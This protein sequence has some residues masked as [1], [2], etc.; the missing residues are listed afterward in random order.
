MSANCLHEAMG[1]VAYY[2]LKPI[3]AC[4]TIFYYVWNAGRILRSM[5]AASTTPFNGT[6]P[7]LPPPQLYERLTSSRCSDRS[8]DIIL[9]RQLAQIEA[10]RARWSLN[11]PPSYRTYETTREL[12]PQL[13]EFEFGLPEKEAGG[14]IF[15]EKHFKIVVRPMEDDVRPKP[16]FSQPH[17]DEKMIYLPGSYGSHFGMAVHSTSAGIGVY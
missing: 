8:T 4:H 1:C 12:P 9:Q 11:R 10:E 7:S 3:V 2:T 6:T 14:K 13:P 17:F 16:L 15:P 5:S